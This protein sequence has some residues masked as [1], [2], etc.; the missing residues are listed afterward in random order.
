M[1]KVSAVV[2]VAKHIS[3]G[4]RERYEPPELDGIDTVT[5]Y[6]YNL[7]RRLTEIERPGGETVIF[8]Y[9]TGG[10]LDTITSDAGVVDYSYH[11]DTGQL[12]T[13]DTSDGIR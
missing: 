7:D 9:D 11:P 1:L 3:P 8:D 5:I 12:A 6:R 2:S 10:R 13:I 4:D